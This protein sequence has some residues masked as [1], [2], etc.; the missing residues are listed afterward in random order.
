MSAALTQLCDLVADVAMTNATKLREQFL[1]LVRDEVSEI[2]PGSVLTMLAFMNWTFAQGSW[3]NISNTKLRRDL[4]IQLKDA[5]I[6]RLARELTGGSSPPDAAARAVAINDQF[7]AYLRQYNARMQSL[8][9]PDSRTATLFAFEQIQERCG[10][11]DHV[12]NDVVPKLIPPE[13]LGT[14][15]ESVALEVNKAAAAK[16][17]G[18]LSKL[19]RG[20]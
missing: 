17:G 18:F 7:T 12:M 6:L 2:D 9:D 15:V 13:G 5:L 20:G 3:S 16:R 14:E 8:G 4:Q 10:L 11:S 19:F 1:Q